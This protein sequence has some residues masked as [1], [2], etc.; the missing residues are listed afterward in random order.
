V[1]F[2]EA[3]LRE[4]LRFDLPDHEA[5]QV[6]RDLAKGGLDA[7]GTFWVLGW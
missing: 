6:A 1:P 7:P 2:T 5:E 3:D 4:A